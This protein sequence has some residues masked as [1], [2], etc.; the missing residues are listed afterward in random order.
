M[1]DDE[2]QGA[3]R[4]DESDRAAILRRRQRFIFLAL[5]GLTGAAGCDEPA[6]PVSVPEVVREQP[7]GDEEPEVVP[8]EASEEVAVS[9]AELPPPAPDEPYVVDPAE[10]RHAEEAKRRAQRPQACLSI[11]RPCLSPP[12]QVCLSP[13]RDPWQKGGGGPDD[14][15]V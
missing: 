10:V 14:E 6:P 8:T 15:P 4:S 7:A 13:L 11:R 3:Q 2:D 1:N 5:S 9:E 12:P